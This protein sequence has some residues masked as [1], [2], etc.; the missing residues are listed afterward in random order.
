VSSKPKANHRRPCHCM[1]PVALLL[2]AWLT[3]AAGPR[4]RARCAH[5]R[6]CSQLARSK[7]DR[8]AKQSSWDAAGQ[9]K[10]KAGTECTPQH[11][12]SRKNHNRPSSHPTVQNTKV[13]AMQQ[14]VS[15]WG[16]PAKQ[17]SCGTAYSVAR[18]RKA[19]SL[20]HSAKQHRAARYNRAP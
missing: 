12:F 1:V 15:R 16:R 20:E 18:C 13:L 6:P 2:E 11:N 19:R 8:P 9:G 5:C 14:A 4:L 3:P 17:P 10:R 7:M